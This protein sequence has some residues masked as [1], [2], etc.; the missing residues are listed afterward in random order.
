MSQWS[1]HDLTSKIVEILS[2]VSGE[3]HFGRP[4]LTAYQLAIEL[5]RRYPNMVQA[6]GLPLGGAGTGQRTSLAQ[7]LA[8]ELSRQIKAQGNYPVEGALLASSDLAELVYQAPDGTTVT[9]TLADAGFDLSMFR[10]R[11]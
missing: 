7:Y 3:H 9:S 11:H 2:D 10:L 4:Y 1:Q 8:R 6:I 5:H